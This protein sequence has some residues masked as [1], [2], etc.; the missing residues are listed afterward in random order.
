MRHLPYAAIIA[1]CAGSVLA[2]MMIERHKDSVLPSVAFSAETGRGIAILPGVANAA[3]HP[4]GVCD[5]AIFDSEPACVD[6]GIFG[7]RPR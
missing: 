7:G 3:A 1:A 6:L 2:G 4:K 5:L